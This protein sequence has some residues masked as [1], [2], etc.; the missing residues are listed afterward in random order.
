MPQRQPESAPAAVGR[1]D[2]TQTATPR[3]AAS[4]D[5]AGSLGRRWPTWAA[6]AFTVFVV[7]DVPDGTDLAP[8]V[9]GAALAYL[10]AAALRSPWTAW[11]WFFAAV[12]VILATEPLVGDNG[13][14]TWVLVGLAVPV[15]AYGLAT[16]ATQDHDGIVHTAVA[17]VGFGAAMAI[18]LG[19]SET[20]GAY[21]VAAA[22]LA[23]TAWD[24]WHYRANRVVVRSLSE[25]CVVLDT[26]VAAVIVIT[27]IS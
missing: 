12:V 21:L 4:P 5:L 23:H 17:M 14:T 3:L 10:G 13:E 24:I 27:T 1:A 25:F 26:L 6:I 9:A 16:G 22:L 20:V 7:R 8:V 15:F 19:A 18:A 11:P 2:R